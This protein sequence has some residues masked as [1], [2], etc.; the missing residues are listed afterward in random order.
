MKTYALDEKTWIC[1]RRKVAAVFC[2]ESLVL[3]KIGS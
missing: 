1:L 2:N 3:K